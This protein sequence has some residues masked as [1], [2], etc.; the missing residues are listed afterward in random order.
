MRITGKEGRGGG[1]PVQ[2][3]LAFWEAE[4]AVQLHVYTGQS[5]AVTE[6]AASA[7]QWQQQPY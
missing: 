2:G 4:A 6:V 3:Y 7:Q 1:D 5:Y